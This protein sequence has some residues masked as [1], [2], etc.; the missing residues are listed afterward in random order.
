MKKNATRHQKC[1]ICRNIPDQ[2]EAYW[3]GG[4]LMGDPLPAAEGKLEIVGAPFFDDSQ[5]HSH[6]CLKQCPKCG[7][8]Y[9]WSFS[10]EFLVNGS[11]DD[12]I[13]TRL[14][15][16]EGE[17]RAKMVMASIKSAEE[18]FRSEAES[19]VKTLLNSPDGKGVYG[20][21]H[22][23]QGGQFKGHDLGF[24]VDALVQALI[25]VCELGIEDSFLNSCASQIYFVLSDEVKK[26]Q[27]VARDMMDV[28]RDLSRDTKGV[29]QIAWLIDDCRGVLKPRK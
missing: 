23:L 16:K 21:A 7:T 12:I 2:A 27:D 6:S 22:F 20:A 17:R 13:L 3:K 15:D 1:S 18:K 26:S 5:T 9:D 10:Y 24:A 25:R 28:L 8:Y 11:E 4:D 19:R 14:G 29:K